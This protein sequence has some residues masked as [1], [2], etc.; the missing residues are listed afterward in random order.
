M[1]TAAVSPGTK[2]GKSFTTA[3]LGLAT[4]ALGLGE[5]AGRAK[6]AVN[7]AVEDRIRIA[8]EAARKGR[9]AA[10]DFRDH[11]KLLVR[12]QPFQ[13]LGWA[14]AGGTI[15]GGALLYAVGRRRPRA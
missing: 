8:R 6:L 12:R 10:E 9:Y 5:K 2:N 3:A 4:T 7:H 13:S 14:F 11:T 15:F 1:E